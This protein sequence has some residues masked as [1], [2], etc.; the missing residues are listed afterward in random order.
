VPEE[1]AIEAAIK[2]LPIGPFAGHLTKEKPSTIEDLCN[3]FEKYYKTNSSR[4]T[5]PKVASNLQETI[6][7]KT[8]LHE[9]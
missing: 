6:E 5:I 4:T 3:K 7:I 1:V 2:G 9:A 8:N